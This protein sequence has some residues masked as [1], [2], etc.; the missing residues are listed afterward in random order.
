MEIGA[1][2][3]AGSGHIAFAGVATLQIDGAILPA[4]QIDSFVK[5]DAVTLHAYGAGDRI[6]AGPIRNGGLEP[7]GFQPG[8]SCYGAIGG[9]PTF[10]G[11]A[12]NGG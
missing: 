5:G 3:S 4:N 9:L 8:P 6:S 7:I 10:A 11:G 2:A 1:G 12:G